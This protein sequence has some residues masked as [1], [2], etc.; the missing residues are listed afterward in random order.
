MSGE[1][2]KLTHPLCHELWK[3]VL[4][5]LLFSHMYYTYM[6]KKTLST[7]EC[8]SGYRPHTEVGIVSAFSSCHQLCL[9]RISN[10]ITSHTLK[11]IKHHR[12]NVA[13]VTYHIYSDMGIV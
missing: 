6:E 12:P 13:T 2:I 10:P 4:Y 5:I 9:V 7:T 3:V 11:N 8:S 1:D